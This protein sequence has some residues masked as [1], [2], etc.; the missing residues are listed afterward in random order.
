[1]EEKLTE[2]ARWKTLDSRILHK[3]PFWTYKMDRFEIPGKMRGEYYFVTTNG[4]SMVI[5]VTEDGKVG[6]VKQYRYLCDRDCIEFPCGSVKPNSDHLETAHAE[7]A[8]EAGV[9]AGN[10]QLIGEYNPYNGVTTEMC[11]VYLATKLIQTESRPDAT[12]EFER[13]WLLPAELDALIRAG[14]IWDGMTLA[15]WALAQPHLR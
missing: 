13:L 3:N 4:S 7:L 10:M 2:L 6:L 12:E 15:A 11:N 5:P 1:M 8:E 14:E 9:Q